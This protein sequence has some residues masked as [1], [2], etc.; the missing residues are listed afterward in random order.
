ML[1][2][3][4]S[5][6]P[7]GAIALTPIYR[8]PFRGRAAHHPINVLRHGLPRPG[9]ATD[10]NIW[11]LQNLPNLWRGL[12]RVWLAELLGIA[13]RYG[14]VF[15]RKQ[16]G[17]S[18]RWTEYG[19][20][21]LRVVTTTGVNYLAAC[22]DNT[23]EPELFKFHGFGTGTTAEA[24]GDSALVTEETTQYNPDSTRPTGSQAHATNTYT[25][26]GTYTPDSGGTRAVTEHGVFSASSAG[27]LLDRS[28][29]AVVNLDSTQGDSLQATYVFTLTAGS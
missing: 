26:I 29:F 28:K 23:S 27:T 20:A 1:F 5:L 24:V 15:L 2:K 6:H 13:T 19:L 3:I 11:R 4:G 18:G 22:M 10:V 25:T 14:A 17:V 21:S 8:D 7:S 16:D 12:W 9:L